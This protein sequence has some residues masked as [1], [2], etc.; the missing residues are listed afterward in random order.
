MVHGCQ[1]LGSE[2][3]ARYI[4]TR[5]RLRLKCVDRNRPLLESQSCYQND[6]VGPCDFS[7][8]MEIISASG[9]RKLLGQATDSGSSDFV[10]GSCRQPS[11]PQIEPNTP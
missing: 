7:T 8:L 3:K 10:P 2:Q 4:L 11:D 1:V 9:R 6:T 5:I